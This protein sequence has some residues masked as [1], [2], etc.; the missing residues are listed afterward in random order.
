MPMGKLDCIVVSYNWDK[1][2]L[3]YFIMGDVA[4]LLTYDR[5][6]SLP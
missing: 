4:A 6:G 1:G 3:Y 2:I 5:I